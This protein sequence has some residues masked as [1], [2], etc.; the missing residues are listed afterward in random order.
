[1]TDAMREYL[2]LRV[3]ETLDQGE[4]VAFLE[5]RFPK[6]TRPIGKHVIEGTKCVETRVPADSP[7]FREISTFVDTKR[8]QGEKDYKFFPIASYLRKYTKD[9]LRSAEVLTLNISSFFEPSGE[10]CGTIYETQCQECN[11]GRQ[12]S[13]LILDLRRAPQQKDMGQTIAWVEWIVSSRF[14]RIFHEWNLRGAEFRPVFEFKN[15]TKRSKDWYQLWIVGKAGKLSKE[16]KLGRDAF[17]PSEIDW[18][19]RLGHSVV[20]GF[21]SEIYLH[22]REFD[23][24]D[25]AITGD[26]FGQG[27]NLLRPAPLIVISS[28]LYQLL[29]ENKIKG[30]S[31]EIARLV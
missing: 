2:I 22:R 14:V 25:I 18:R 21:P 11:K 7:E 8:K 29:D 10:E 3:S 5:A 17:S 19:C 31:C 9:E 15:P 20:T 27:R 12:V 30:F 23:G 6:A 13:D 4:L 24:S 26:L 1:M 16:T 28:R